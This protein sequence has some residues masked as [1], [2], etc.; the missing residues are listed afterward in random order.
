MKM[1][2]SDRRRYIGELPKVRQKY[3]EMALK[4]QKASESM[5]TDPNKVRLD[6]VSRRG[7]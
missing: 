3:N 7:K 5:S 2:V 6:T 1:N 4:N